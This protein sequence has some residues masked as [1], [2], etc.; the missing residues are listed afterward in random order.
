M[1]LLRLPTA[2]AALVL[3]SVAIACQSTG[4]APLTGDAPAYTLVFLHGATPPPALSPE[5]QEAAMGG[6]FSNMAVLAEQGR[7]LV[8]GPLGPPRSEA[9]HRGIFL[10]NTGDL[11]QARAWTGTDPSIGAGI[12]VP[13]LL[14]CRSQAPLERI[15][16]LDSAATARRM[17]ED[18]TLTRNTA[19]V[20][21]AYVLA[22]APAS[23]ARAATAATLEAAGDALITLEVERD[24]EAG[25]T[26]G[27]PTRE[28]WL[29]LDTTGPEEARALLDAHVGEWELH[30]WYATAVLPEL[31]RDAPR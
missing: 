3:A 4:P 12:F 18:P 7:L 31:R 16:E 30:G 26:L 21:R 24:M 1:K 27:T 17:E 8:A 2:I 6:H 28:L 9:S 5:D 25:D 20:G 23:A 19:W 15:V 29:V 10:L 14:L 13:E 11:D 22:S